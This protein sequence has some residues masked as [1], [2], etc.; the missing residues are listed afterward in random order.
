MID[1][2]GKLVNIDIDE[3]REKVL[4]SARL[5]NIEVLDGSVEYMLSEW[6]AKV[7]LDIDNSVYLSIQ[8]FL[9]PTGQDIDIQNPGIARLVATKSNG[10]IELDN[11]LGIDT[12][13]IPIESIF[14]G[15]NGISYTNPLEGLT[16]L[17]GEI[18]FVYI[19]SVTTGANTNLPQNQNFLLTPHTLTNPQ[20]LAGGR[21][22]ETDSDYWNR[23]IY[24]RTNLASEQTSI[25]IT[26]A[27]LQ[28]YL[29]AKIFVN[30]SNSSTLTPIPIPSN[31]YNCALILPSGVN[32]PARELQKAIETF[33]SLAEFVGV[34]NVSTVNHPVIYGVSFS[35]VFPVAYSVTPVQAVQT[36]VNLTVKVR[37]DSSIIEVEKPNLAKQFANNFVNRLMAT[38][39]SNNGSYNFDFNPLTGSNTIETIAV[40]GIVKQ[41]NNIAPIVSIEA[42][43]SIIY[44][45]SDSISI[46]GL[47]YRECTELTVEFDPLVIGESPVILSIDAPYEGSVLSVD[48]A[49]DSLFLDGTSWFDRWINLDPSFISVA[50]VEE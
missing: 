49:K 7:F 45:Q 24:L 34:N 19:E 17:A 20:P 39:Y 29:D 21:D 26:N 32:A 47:Q 25:V 46:K 6:L 48:F 50:I 22:L 13:T 18:G 27:L 16:V 3:A 40:N 36:T 44:D 43:R 42:I 23:I 1:E 5:A 38:F 10:Y 9:Y 11:T 12:I 15:S 4:E 35:G 14:T 33:V 28:Y 8:K 37:F 30:N 31:G 2:N 41:N